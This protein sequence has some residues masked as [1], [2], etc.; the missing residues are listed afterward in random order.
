MLSV[1]KISPQSEEELCSLFAADARKNGWAVY[2]EQGTWDLLLVRGSGKAAVVQVGVQAKLK[3]NL[4]VLSQALP[5]I[6]RSYRNK[7]QFDSGPHYRVVLI[8]SY[9]GRKPK[10]QFTYSQMFYH[11]AVFLKIVVA[12]CRFPQWINAGYA[13]NK[14][15]GR[16]RYSYRGRLDLRHYRWKSDQLVWIPPFVPDL[17]AGVKSPQTV[18]PW[19][20]AAVQLENLCN[21]QGYVCVSDAKDVIACVCGDSGKQFRPQTILNRH[22]RSTGERMDGSNQHKW[23]LAQWG[24]LPSEKYPAVAAAIPPTIPPGSKTKMIKKTL[25]QLRTYDG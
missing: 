10:Q 21:H 22:F 14:H 18:S 5:P 12:D 3:A 15:I 20:L 19:K 23:V 1:A 13:G 25:N 16:T 7:K 4:H 24:K 17:P 11:L 2:P 8:G 6:S 9:P